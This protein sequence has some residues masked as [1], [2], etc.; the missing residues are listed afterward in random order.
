MSELSSFVI[1]FY[2]TYTNGSAV[3]TVVT[4]PVVPT[5]SSVTTTIESLIAYIQANG[6]NFSNYSLVSDGVNSLP[7][8]NTS[9]EGDETG[10]SE[11]MTKIKSSMSSSTSLITNLQALLEK[12]KAEGS[13]IDITTPDMEEATGT[14]PSIVGNLKSRRSGGQSAVTNFEG[15]GSKVGTLEKDSSKLFTSLSKFIPTVKNAINSM[16][17]GSSSSNSGSTTTNG[18]TSSGQPTTSNSTNSSNVNNTS[19]TISGNSNATPNN[20]INN[21]AKSLMGGSKVPSLI[22]KRGTKSGS[23]SNSGSM[24]SL[25]T[26]PIPVP[27]STPNTTGVSQP[28]DYYQIS[29]SVSNG[30]I[31]VLYSYYLANTTTSAYA[32]TF[33]LSPKSLISLSLC[34][35]S[36]AISSSST[37]KTNIIDHSCYSGSTDNIGI[38]ISYLIW[39]YS[40]LSIGVGS[41]LD[42]NGIYSFPEEEQGS[43]NYML[44]LQYMQK[45][46]NFSLTLQKS[47]LSSDKAAFLDIGIPYGWSK[48]MYSF[49]KSNK[50]GH[51]ENYMAETVVN[52]IKA[53]TETV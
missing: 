11:M 51:Q 23:T 22:P 40:Y 19:G 48:M 49:D 45:V 1:D 27:T 8:S 13:S 3:T 17:T 10:Y 33:S 25:N 42:L 53:Y 35:Y 24:S 6:V 46:G 30:Y 12:V 14:T 26:F 43:I 21:I 47:T 37:V 50:Y 16:N 7:Y 31:N 15:L 32:F 52:T 34:G 44:D 29:T 39:L 2:V 9:V 5:K 36:K 41:Q 28:T 38:W 20:I 18:V 4:Q